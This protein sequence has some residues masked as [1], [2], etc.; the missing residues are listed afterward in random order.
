MMVLA[1]CVHKTARQQLVDFVN[2]PG[3][4]IVQ[5]IKIGDVNITTKWLPK[6]YRDPK[7]ATPDD[8]YY[9]FDVRFEKEKAFKPTKDKVMYL[10]F[11]MQ[12]DFVMGCAGDSIAPSI[13]Q[14]IENGMTG[15]YQYMVAFENRNKDIKQND[16]VLVYNDKIFGIGSIAFVYKKNDIKKIPG[17]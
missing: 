3:N 12:K 6:H 1:G 8:D 9:Y 2:D 15:S 11:D 4:K 10:D 5:S 7:S 13:C 14:K 16:F 17:L